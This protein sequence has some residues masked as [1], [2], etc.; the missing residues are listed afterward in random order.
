VPERFNR[1]EGP[2]ATDQIVRYLR[3][4]SRVDVLDLREKLI[5]A[6]KERPVYLL[7]DSHWNE[8]GAFAGY[9][10]IANRLHAMFPEIEP[11]R[12]DRLKVVEIPFSGDLAKMLNLSDQL[13]ER[14]VLLVP[15][16]QKSHTIPFPLN[17]TPVP[18]WLA[19]P[20]AARIEGSKLPKAL[21]YHDSFMYQ[22]M[23]FV[24]EHF[25]TV[26]YI[27]DPHVTVTTVKDFH[28]DIVIHECVERLL[29]N[30]IGLNDDLRPAH[31]SN[32]LAAGPASASRTRK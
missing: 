17:A 31:Q 11:L 22:M 12:L 19:P 25:E 27:R 24:S 20:M 1:L 16:P 3:A 28:P 18:T 32:M 4:R 26:A 13:G 21:V 29:R 8:Y 15:V 9:E 6:R 30:L 5:A 7:R 10:A 14:R 23:P 2:S